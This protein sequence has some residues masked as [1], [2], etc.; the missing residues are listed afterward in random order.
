MADIAF[1]RDIDAKVA[2]ELGWSVEKVKANSDFL[3]KRMKELMLREDIDYI[4][5]T[6]LGQMYS[7]IYML[8]NKIRSYRHFGKE[9]KKQWVDKIERY[10]KHFSGVYNYREF[11]TF[12][13]RLRILT[14][15]LT[16]G[17]NFKELQEFQN[18][19]D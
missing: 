10:K 14:K 6:H 3:I 2:K 13:R 8:E 18:G 9:P 7:K 1:K 16:E 12:N 19:E 17:K 4:Q 11:R 15:Y 5:M